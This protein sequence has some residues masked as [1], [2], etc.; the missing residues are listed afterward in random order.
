M[1]IY[2]AFYIML[3]DTLKINSKF[4]KI[5]GY[6]KNNLMYPQNSLK[7][8]NTLKNYLQLFKNFPINLYPSIVP[9]RPILAENSLYW[10]ISSLIL[11]VEHIA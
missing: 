10:L 9:Y 5:K 1:W 11:F 6:L 3:M 2:N 4:L 8:I 7:L